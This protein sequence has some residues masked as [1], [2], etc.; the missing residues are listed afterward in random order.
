MCYALQ[1]QAKLALENLQKAIELNPRYREEAKTEPEFEEL[2]K[3]KRFAQLIG[4]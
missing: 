2:A 1:G 3:T 4:G